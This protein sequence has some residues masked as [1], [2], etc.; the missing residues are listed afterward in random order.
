[1]V[2]ALAALAVLAGAIAVATLVAGDDGDGWQEVTDATRR[3]RVAVPDD[4]DHVA[5]DPH[6]IAGRPRAYVEASPDQH[7]YRA[8]RDAPGLELLLVEGVSDLD[9]LV[10]DVAERTGVVDDCRKRQG[11]AGVGDGIDAVVEV[12]EDCDGGG[13][14][15]LV[16]LRHGVD[17]SVV[18]GIQSDD[19]ELVERVLAGIEV[20]SGG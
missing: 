10:A 3:L 4:W 7:A 1:M 12:W 5:T 14:I 6:E 13:A 2:R 18:G 16:A 9:A 19:D 20:V 11:P 15:Y 17:A 8:G